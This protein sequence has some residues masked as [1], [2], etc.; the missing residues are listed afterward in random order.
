[1][2]ESEGSERETPLKWIE[3]TF[4]VD[5]TARQRNTGFLVSFVG[6]IISA[7]FIGLGIMTQNQCPVQ[8]FLPTWMLVN[9]SQAAFMIVAMTCFFRDVV[10]RATRSMVD[11]DISGHAFEALAIHFRNSTRTETALFVA[12]L[13]LVVFNVIWW[14]I[15]CY[16]TIS[17]VRI[18][19]L[20]VKEASKADKQQWFCDPVL[21][22]TSFEMI[23]M[24]WVILGLCLMYVVSLLVYDETTVRSVKRFFRLEIVY[25]DEVEYELDRGNPSR[26]SA[27]RPSRQIQSKAPKGMTSNTLSSR[28]LT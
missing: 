15:G 25:N 5:A 8:P 12:F 10:K 2:S 6:L 26:F 28:A 23:V 1:M 13:V 11:E 27:L 17:V 20:D 19:Y 7:F 21:F 3:K 4:D 18:V 24:A 22:T 14:L 9:A 16:L